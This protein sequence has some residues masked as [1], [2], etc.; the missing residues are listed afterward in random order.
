MSSLNLDALIPAHKLMLVSQSDHFRK[1][2]SGNFKEAQEG[3]I[4]IFDSS[5]S[6]FMKGFNS[7]FPPF[8]SLF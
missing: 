6:M 1:L 5:P 2:F 4:K 8:F 7:S 3:V